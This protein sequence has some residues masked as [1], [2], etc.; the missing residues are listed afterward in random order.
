L[1]IEFHSK[2]MNR[3]V[4][5]LDSAHKRDS[6]G[7]AAKKRLDLKFLIKPTSWFFLG[8]LRGLAC[9]EVTY[10]GAVFFFNTLLALIG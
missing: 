8:V 9:P 10:S 1:K 5:L 4:P 6:E 7:E 2:K 3:Q